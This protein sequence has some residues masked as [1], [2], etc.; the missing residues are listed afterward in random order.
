MSNIKNEIVKLRERL[1]I[2][3]YLSFADGY[4]NGDIKDTEISR[5]VIAF[6]IQ[7]ELALEELQKLIENATLDEE[8]I[9]QIIVTCATF[10]GKESWTTPDLNKSV[11][12]RL[13]FN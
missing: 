11:I 7:A 10:I 3:A 1:R 8:E 4:A 2:P 9:I 13:H 5:L 6:K 12:G